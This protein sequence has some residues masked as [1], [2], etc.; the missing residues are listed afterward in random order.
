[1]QRVQAAWFR[2]EISSRVRTHFLWAQMQ[3]KQHT[4]P[5]HHHHRESTW[6]MDTGTRGQQLRR[7][8]LWN[9]A[10]MSPSSDGGWVYVDRCNQPTKPVTEWFISQWIAGRFAGGYNWWKHIENP[11]LLKKIYQT[12]YSTQTY[13]NITQKLSSKSCNTFRAYNEWMSEPFQ[14]R[15]SFILLRYSFPFLLESSKSKW[16]WR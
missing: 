4:V 6:H 2:H 10:E 9:R 13:A 7:W 8:K 1:M 15:R 12:F 16:N 11:F 3:G 5:S 14:I